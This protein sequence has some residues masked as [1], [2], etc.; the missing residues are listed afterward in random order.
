MLNLPEDDTMMYA[1]DDSVS[2]VQQKLQKCLINSTTWIRKN[3][4]KMIDS[5]KL[6][7]MLIETNSELKSSNNEQP[8]A[9][10]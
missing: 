4:L 2:E 8:L 9:I 5:D 7:V 3:C 1:S 10:V 6:E